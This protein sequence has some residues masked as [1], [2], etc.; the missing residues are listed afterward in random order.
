MN[1]TETALA[2]FLAAAAT[3]VATGHLQLPTDLT[4]SSLGVA[5]FFILALV[6]YA[7]SPVVGIAAVIL[8]AVIL[9]NRNVEKVVKYTAISELSKSSDN[10]RRGEYGDMNIAA[11][12]NTVHPYASVASGPRDYS[13][14][15]ETKNTTWG[16]VS[17]LT[18]GFLSGAPLDSFGFQQYATG[19]FPID[20]KRNWANPFIAEEQFRPALGM[21]DDSFQRGGPQMDQKL[22]AIAYH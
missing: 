7:Y 18:E 22:A 17:S 19:Q 21:G 2:V 1:P 20:E 5:G 16:P 9:F 8:F 3:A 10:P 4:H 12:R 15:R 14:F 6:L 13:Q 11:E